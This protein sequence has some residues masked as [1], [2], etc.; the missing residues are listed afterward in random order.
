MEHNFGKVLVLL[1]IMVII[2]IANS[3]LRRLSLWEDKYAVR[4]PS[5]IRCQS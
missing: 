1:N 5:A 3:Q 4:D 2:I